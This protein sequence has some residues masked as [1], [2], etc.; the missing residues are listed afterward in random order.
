[1][2]DVIAK[3]FSSAAKGIDSILGATVVA[4]NRGDQM[5]KHDQ[6]QFL[7]ELSKL[8]NVDFEIKASLVGIDKPMKVSAS[9]PIFSLANLQQTTF[10]EVT[11]DLA[12]DVSDHQELEI[13]TDTAIKA[14]GTAKIGIGPIGAKVHISA[15]MGVH[16]SQKRSTDQRS[17]VG[18]QAVLE[19]TEPPEGVQLIVDTSNLL[20]SKTMEMNVKIIEGKVQQIQA[21]V[22][23]EANKPPEVEKPDNGEGD[24]TGANP[25]A[26]DDG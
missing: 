21:D 25:A 15:S 7:E 22:E 1:M 4:V 24:D 26:G 9:L 13:S 16:S 17:H 19:R 23:A 2:A 5:Q 6:I 11:L 3:G 8:E 12:M 20:V 18:L 10:K 14:E